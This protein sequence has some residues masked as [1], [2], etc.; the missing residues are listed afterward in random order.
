MTFDALLASILFDQIG[1]VGEAHASIPIKCTDGLYHASA[2]YYELID[3]S[4]VA[5]VANMRADHALDADL[6]HKKADG[7][8]HKRLGR[9][10]RS[11]FGAVMNSYTLLAAETITWF[12]EG[13]RE[14]I[15][16]LVSE[17]A[18]I[19]KRR[20][21]GNGEV[22]NWTIEDGE[23]NG[24]LGLQNEPLRP[25]PEDMFNG[26]TSALRVD[27]GWK[28]AYWDPVNRAICYVPD[29]LL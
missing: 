15:H 13:D 22:S 9:L 12:V 27:T 24:L 21:S 5:F 2:A 14:V 6:I 26:D 4:R 29:T 1:D 16:N 28:P 3:Q 23:L 17:V 25:I 7:S 10:R 11:D 18:F 19:G 8:T 20:A